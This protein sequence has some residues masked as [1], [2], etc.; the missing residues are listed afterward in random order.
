[1]NNL[2]CLVRALAHIK[3]AQASCE[4]FTGNRDFLAN[5][6][7]PFEDIKRFIADSITLNARL[8]KEPAQQPI[9]CD[10]TDRRIMRKKTLARLVPSQVREIIQRI[11]NGEQYPD[12]AK[13]YG[14]GSKCIG[15]I[16]LCKTWREIPRNKVQRHY[17]SKR[18]R[19]TITASVCG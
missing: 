5:T 14:V 4:K 9:Q 16:A 3:E 6:E 2:D 1:M 7:E 19:M 12:I 10:N 17:Q 11:N 15:D 8:E 13:D 18:R